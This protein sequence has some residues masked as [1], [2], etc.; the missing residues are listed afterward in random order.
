MERLGARP[1]TTI[2]LG[3]VPAVDIRG[4]HA[5]GIRPLLL[6]RHDLYPEPDAPRLQSIERLPG[7]LGLPD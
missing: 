7:W 4:A 5:A 1:A 3:D 6:D 2:F